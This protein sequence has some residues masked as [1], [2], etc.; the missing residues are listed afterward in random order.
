LEQLINDVLAGGTVS[1]W[2]EKLDEAGVPCGPLNTAGQAL[3]HPQTRAIGMVMDV[4]DGQGGTE[5]GLG[6]PVILNQT[7]STHAKS[8]APQVG[9][10]TQTVLK[11]FG[12]SNA[13]IAELQEAQ[14]IRQH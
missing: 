7:P 9:E 2:C 11:E 12:F 1:H 3:E 4:S 14:V 6:L 5:P 13:E 8:C 10:H